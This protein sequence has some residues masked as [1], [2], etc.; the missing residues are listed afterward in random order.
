VSLADLILERLRPHFG[1]RYAIER[2]LGQG[3]MATVYLATDLRH[4]RP[5][6]IKVLQ[7]GTV[8]GPERFLREIQLAAGLTHPHI[9]P[10]YDSGGVGELLYYVM[11]FIEGESLRDRLSREGKVAVADAVQ[12]GRQVAE[13]LA[14]AHAHSVI[15]RDIKPGNIL[16]SGYPPRDRGTAGGCHALVVDFGIA[17][18]I[19]AGGGGGLT[20]AGAALGSPMYMSPEQAGGE[21][22]LDGRSDIYSLG[23]VLYEM[24]TGQPPFTGPTAQAIMISRLLDTP[25]PLRAVQP[26]LPARLEAVVIRAMARDRAER[27][28]SAEELISALSAAEAGAT[29]EP[30]A[31]AT[32]ERLSIA[33]LPFANLS[34]D[35]E[36]EYFSDGVTDELTNALAKIAGLRVTSRTSA[37]AF[38]GKERDVKDIGRRLGVG[39]LLEGSVRKAGNRLRISAHLVNTGD[40]Y[41][42]W[43]ETYDR[44]LTDVFAVQD[45]ISRTI[46]GAL[47][48]KLVGRADAAL[49]EAGTTN[50]EAYNHYLK[51]RY[52]SSSRTPDGLKRAI[53]QFE[54]AIALDPLYAAAHAELGAAHALRGFEEYPDLPPRETMP[55]AKQAV[56]RALQLD[57]SLGEGHAWLGVIAWLYDWDA[58]S[59][60]R[61]LVRAI[62]LQPQYSYAHVWYAMLLAVSRRGEESIRAINRARNLDPVSPIVALSTARCYYWLGQIDE[63]QRQVEALLEIN[64]GYQLAYTWLA[65][66]LGAQGREDEAL[67]AMQRAESLGPE[68]LVARAFL[69][70]AYGR[71]GHQERARAILAELE[72][73]AKR[74]WVPAYFRFY[75]LMGLGDFDGAFRMLE[76]AV[77]ERS[78]YLSF[79]S[80]APDLR[81]PIEA[82][83]AADPRLQEIWRRMAQQRHAASDPQVAVEAGG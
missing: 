41:Q 58:T 50:L 75:V 43:S 77:Q 23:C 35:P 52:L 72:A 17:R 6:A 15:H 65:R 39:T 25:P 30:V 19:D 73:E 3:G 67:A 8:L 24:V 27:F 42:V 44:D 59:A 34:A 68:S 26:D 63:A 64:P 69:G 11:P 82:P 28:A 9:V 56:A 29:S 81:D 38:K 80:G 54:R 62:V 48:L 31:A 47:R 79:I 22:Q 51:G 60:E 18:A 53:E 4:N 5:V 46:A 10:L 45:E 21:P 57:P 61:E 2:E 36:N 66:T 14:Y 40:G 78:G 20:E 7:P 37:F 55:Q 16:L 33:V 71:A 76:I 74:R 13:A 70:W 49:V 12:I 32:Q 83:I 1:D